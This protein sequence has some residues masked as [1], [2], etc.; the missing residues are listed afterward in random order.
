M[1]EFVDILLKAGIL[2]VLWI[3]SD[4]VNHLVKTLRAPEQSQPYDYTQHDQQ[5]RSHL[6]EANKEQRRPEGY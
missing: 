5:P 4:G 2:F 1:Y 3:L 6:Y